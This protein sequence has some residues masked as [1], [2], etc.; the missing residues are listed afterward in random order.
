MEGKLFMKSCRAQLFGRGSSTPDPRSL[1][2]MPGA[3]I[4]LGKDLWKGFLQ[5]QILINRVDT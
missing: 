2:S 4:I 5:C 1:W 3:G